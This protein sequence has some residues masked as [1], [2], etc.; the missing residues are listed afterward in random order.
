[1]KQYSHGFAG[2]RSGFSPSKS[3]QEDPIWGNYTLDLSFSSSDDQRSGF[4]EDDSLSNL[5]RDV[6]TTKEGQIVEEK[7]SCTK[8]V[9]SE[10]LQLLI[11]SAEMS[12]GNTTTFVSEKTLNGS[13]QDDSEE[14]DSPCWVG[15]L[16][17]KAIIDSGAK[18][19]ASRRSSDDLSG[20]QR[21]NP[22][23]PRFVPSSSTKN[24]D[25]GEI[26]CEEGSTSSLKKSLS[27][28]FPS[29]SS[30]EFNVTDPPEDGRNVAATRT[31]VLTYNAGE[32]VDSVTQGNVSTALITSDSRNEVQPSK[33]LD[34]LAPVFV[35]S[36]AK[37][38]PLVHEKQGSVEIKAPSTF[39]LTSSDKKPLN[40]VTVV[41]RSGEAGHSVHEVGST[42]SY[43]PRNEPKAGITENAK[44]GS[45]SNKPQGLRRLNPLAPQFSL[46]STK[47]KAYVYEKKQIVDDL[48][49]V[50][51]TP[52]FSPSTGYWGHNVGDADFS[53]PSVYVERLLPN[54]SHISPKVDNNFGS[55]KWFTVEPET[56]LSVKGT[57]HF[58]HPIPFHVVETAPSSSSSDPKAL[59]GPSPKMDVKKL[60]TTMHGLSELLTLAHGPESYNSHDSEELD[61]INSTVQNLNLYTNNNVQEQAWDQTTT[62]YNSYDLTMLPRKSKL[63]IRDLQLPTANSMTFNLDANR[64][65]NYSMVSG[66]P[67][68][69]EYGATTYNGFG[70]AVANSSYQQNHQGGDQVNQNALF[71]K[72][73][74]LKAEAERCLMVYETSLSNPTS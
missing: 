22:L 16:S 28:T 24:I 29:S 73:L 49:L 62:G 6:E 39:A 20:F 61:L 9:I 7:M 43:N 46:A 74:W 8:P 69:Y 31:S 40:K 42:S 2:L 35:P 57:N 59:S 4:D 72:S 11:K 27:S 44:I 5:S 66:D 37:L 60:L 65:E 36:S 18:S 21:L 13:V 19:L 51:N 34:P 26:T 52:G 63:P 33:G 64:N 53:Q 45:S 32:N 68:L 38:S 47:P 70:Q 23:A 14:E 10:Q 15:K 50:V 56:T 12:C 67:C 1:M 55:T 54:T 3:E 71:Y 48:S 17:H 41:A 25:T 58:K 30:G